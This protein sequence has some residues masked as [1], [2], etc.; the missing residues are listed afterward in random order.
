[1]YACTEDEN[2]SGGFGNSGDNTALVDPTNCWY[3]DSINSTWGLLSI[4]LY[5]DSGPTKNHFYVRKYIGNCGNPGIPF[6]PEG[7]GSSDGPHNISFTIGSK[8][9]FG[10]I[11]DTAG[12]K[13]MMVISPP[14]STVLFYYSH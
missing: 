9:Y 8:I 10:Y 13:K 2:G 7:I 3:K 6:V 14:D 5:M 1:L 11:S 12:Y 4:F